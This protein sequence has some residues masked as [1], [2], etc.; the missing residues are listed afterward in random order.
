MDSKVNNQ[1]WSHRYGYCSEQHVADG[2]RQVPYDS[3]CPCDWMDAFF[4]SAA[5]ISVDKEE[6]YGN[7]PNA[8]IVLSRGAIVMVLAYCRYG[9]FAVAN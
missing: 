2:E 1:N 9:E 7:K 4:A 6:C 3:Y 8:T 5:E